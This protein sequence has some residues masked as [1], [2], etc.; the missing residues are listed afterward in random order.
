VFLQNLTPCCEIL[1]SHG[2][3]YESSEML[4]CV[5]SYKLTDVS[6]I[7]TASIIRAFIIAL[8]MEAVSTSETSLNIYQTTRSNISEDSL[9][10]PMLFI[11]A[12]F[13]KNIYD[14][15]A[16][17]QLVHDNSCSEDD[18]RSW[19]ANDFSTSLLRDGEVPC[20]TIKGGGWTAR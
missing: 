6:D 7:R 15:D 5:V 16:S 9:R 18:D 10:N 3:E 4:L 17:D 19:T 11:P 13:T 8:M 12:S 14:Y 2:G 1:G 20:R